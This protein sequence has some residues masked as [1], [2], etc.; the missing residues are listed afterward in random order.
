MAKTAVLITIPDLLSREDQEAFDNHWK[1]YV[2][3]GW[4]WTEGMRL[5]ALHAWKACL[6]RE[7]N[8]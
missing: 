2:S 5:S 3:E 1:E 8:E 6:E 4:E 7:R